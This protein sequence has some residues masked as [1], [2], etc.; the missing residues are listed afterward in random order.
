MEVGFRGRGRESAGVEVVAKGPEGL[1]YVVVGVLG[2]IQ[3]LLAS[4]SKVHRQPL[5][6]LL[7]A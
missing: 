2:F 3:L 5:T 4:C 6:A 7:P 1:S